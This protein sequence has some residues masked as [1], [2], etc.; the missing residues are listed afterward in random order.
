MLLDAWRANPNA[1]FRSPFFTFD[2]WALERQSAPAVV[3]DDGQNLVVSLEIPGVPEADIQLTVTGQTLTVSAKRKLE[4]PDGYVVHQQARQ[5]GTISRSFRLPAK[6]DADSARA[7]VR[8]GVLTV[9]L[10]RAAAEKARAIQVQAAQP[11]A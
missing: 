8:D 2:P 7:V 9:T 10:P 3:T 6:I 1:F 4:V 11:T 5:G